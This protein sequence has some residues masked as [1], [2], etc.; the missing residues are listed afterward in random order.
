MGTYNILP[1]DVKEEIVGLHLAAGQ[2]I[3]NLAMEYGV[4]K[5]SISRWVKEF[6][7]K[8][9]EDPI[10]KEDLDV[11]EKIRLNQELTKEE[12]EVAFL[13]KAAACFANE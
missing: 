9:Q 4:A 5:S 2:T 1:P 13:K 8:A 7:L 6:R 10:A 12:K 3:E 11:Y